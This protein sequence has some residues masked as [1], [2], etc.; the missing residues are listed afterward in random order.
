MYNYE[1]IKKKFIMS[2]IYLY[3]NIVSLINTVVKQVNNIDRL[4]IKLMVIAATGPVFDAVLV[5]CWWYS[6]SLFQGVVMFATNF[7][8]LLIFDYKFSY[9]DDKIK[10]IFL[11]FPNDFVW[12]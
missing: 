2:N 5:C 12:C 9:I 7:P 4:I 3:L 8:M 6:V 10:V 11:V 1:K